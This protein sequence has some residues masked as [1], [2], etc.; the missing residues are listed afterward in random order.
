MKSIR[1]GLLLQ[2]IKKAAEK[3]ESG[4]ITWVMGMFFMLVLSV[5]MVFCL[6]I[7]VWESSSHMAQ[8]ALAMSNLAAA[9]IDIER[10]GTDHSVLITDL[11]GA[12]D[13]FLHAL[14]INLG[15]DDTYRAQNSSLIGGKVIPEVFVV[16]NVDGA[17][18]EVCTYQDGNWRKEACMLDAVYAPNGQK[19]EETSIYSEISYPVKGAWGT[20]IVAH[21]NQLVKVYANPEGV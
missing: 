11:D 15:L 10:Y 14:R 9:I 13:T 7:K 17:V 2:N 1:F 12:H 19:I 8:D 3:K 5:L 20:G 4:A 6:Q 21:K 18:V 16:Y